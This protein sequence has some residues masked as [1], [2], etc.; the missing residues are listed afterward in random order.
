LPYKSDHFTAKAWFQ[1]TWTVRAADDDLFALGGDSGSLVVTE[2]GKSAVGL[3]F[4][5]NTRGDYGI[6]LPIKD[7]LTGLGNPRLVSGHGI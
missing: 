4:A 7:V 3:L 6:I 1:N 2:D 5:A